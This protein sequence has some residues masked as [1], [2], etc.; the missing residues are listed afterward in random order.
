MWIKIILNLIFQ[1][2]FLDFDFQNTYLNSGIPILKYVFK[3]IFLFQIIFPE[4]DF[5][6]PIY[7]W[8]KKNYFRMYFLISDF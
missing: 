1:N 6:F 4:Y 8:N 7:F 3:I 5:G 2:I